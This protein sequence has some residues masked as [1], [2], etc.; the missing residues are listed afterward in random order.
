MDFSKLEAG[1]AILVAAKYG[2]KELLLA[3]LRTDK[4][5]TADDRK[6]LADYLEGK[7]N[8]KKGRPAGGKAALNLRNVAVL[9]EQI[10]A[11]LHKRGEHY[12]IQDKA[13]DFAL[14]LHSS[15]GHP[16]VARETLENHL[17]RSNRRKK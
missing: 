4:P 2:R 17:R 16:P 15:W 7:Y 9:V 10:K 11:E 5:L 6:Y 1:S 3:Y 14:E 8:R 13:V 12:R